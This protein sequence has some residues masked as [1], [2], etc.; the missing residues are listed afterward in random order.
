MFLISRRAI[1]DTGIEIGWTTFE[2]HY[3][4]DTF[5]PEIVIMGDPL[6]EEAYLNQKREDW[7]GWV[8]D[9][10]GGQVTTA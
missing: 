2:L 4:P 6:D 9:Y 5:E 3:K 1:D 8:R 7:L 10:N